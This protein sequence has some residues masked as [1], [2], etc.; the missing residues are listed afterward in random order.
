MEEIYPFL[1][2]GNINYHYYTYK[3]EKILI[4]VQEDSTTKIILGKIIDNKFKIL[5]E[6]ELK[7]SD[8]ATFLCSNTPF[9]VNLNLQNQFEIFLFNGN[10]YKINLETGNINKI[11]NKAIHF[12]K[13]K[14]KYYG[15]LNEIEKK[16]DKNLFI[17]EVYELKLE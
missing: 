7:K 6:N 9:R 12:F 1:K 3:N 13:M 16:E 10:T 17:F 8:Y 4:E 11:L 14:D 15:V 2:E 5:W